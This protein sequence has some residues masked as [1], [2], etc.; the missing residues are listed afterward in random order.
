MAKRG[1]PKT[2]PAYLY[3]LTAAEIGKMSVGQHSA[4]FANALKDAGMPV[5][6][7][8]LEFAKE[9]MGRKWRFDFAFED[10]KTAVEIEGGGFA[11]GRHTR[12]Q[13]FA[14]DMEKYNAAI[15]LGWA[16]LRYNRKQALT[17]AAIEQ[18]RAVHCKR[19]GVCASID[20]AE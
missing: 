18:I 3:G 6:I 2:P 12:G 16:V 20:A 10:S 11:G 19:G 5:L 9:S 13:G 8:E 14:Q 4:L 17:R 15:M 7:R 1:K